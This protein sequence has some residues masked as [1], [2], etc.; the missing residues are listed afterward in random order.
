ML[1][2]QLAVL[3][4]DD[5][6]AERLGGPLRDAAVAL[7]VQQQRVDDGAAV[8][9]AD[10]APEGGPAGLL[11]D[12]HH[13][14]VDAERE[15]LAVGREEAGR[16]QARLVAGR[17]RCRRTPRPAICAERHVLSVRRP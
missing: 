15:R 13:G 14:D 1:G 2:Q 7:A 11:V 16:L 5:L 6:L 12:L 3:V 9:D 4:V 17:A 8:V 10:E